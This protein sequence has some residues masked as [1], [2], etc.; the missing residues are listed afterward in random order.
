M[1]WGKFWEGLLLVILWRIGEV[2]GP[3]VKWDSVEHSSYGLDHNCCGP[4]AGRGWTGP[5]QMLAGLS[6]VKGAIPGIQLMKN[7]LLSS[8][9]SRPSH[10]PCMNIVVLVVQEHS[11][12][13]SRC[14]PDRLPVSCFT[15]I[16]CRA[17]VIST[18]RIFIHLS[19]SSSGDPAVWRLDYHTWILRDHRRAAAAG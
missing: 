17:S 6:E 9:V 4:R 1:L 16:R 11:W 2:N 19:F 18:Q 12:L 13:V 3:E 8:Q 5:V 14:S 7:V 10:S 15:C